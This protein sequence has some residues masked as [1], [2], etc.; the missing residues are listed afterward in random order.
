MINKLVPLTRQLWQQT[1]VKML[2]TPDKFHYIFNLRDLSRIWQGIL[3]VKAEECTTKGSI[4][5]QGSKSL[6]RMV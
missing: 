2:P 1:K 4:L 5:S 3:T 6:L